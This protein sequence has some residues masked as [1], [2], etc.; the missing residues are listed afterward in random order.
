ML[1]ADVALVIDL[2][3]DDEGKALCDFS[4]CKKIRASWKQVLYRQ[5]SLYCI[6]YFFRS[7]PGI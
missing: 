1:N 6:Q 7:V 2:K 3:V 5:L 4:T